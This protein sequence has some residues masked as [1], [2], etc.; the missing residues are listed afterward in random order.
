MI[1]LL[2]HLLDAAYLF[3]VH[4]PPLGA[5]PRGMALAVVGLLAAAVLSGLW[6]RR[7]A[8][9]GR[10]A[11]GARAATLDALLAAVAFAVRPWVAGMVSARVWYVALAAAALLA[12][13]AQWAA[14][15]RW[16]P[17]AHWI[18]LALA[19]APGRPAPRISPA[20]A[21]GWLAL[22]ASGLYAL[23]RGGGGWLPAALAVACLLIA[24][25]GGQRGPLAATA[26]AIWAPLGLVY[27]VLAVRSAL[28]VGLG[29]DLAPYQAFP[30]ADPLSP[31]VHLP[32]ATLAALAWMVLVTG[33]WLRA[34]GAGLRA[35][36]AGLRDEKAHRPTPWP[37]RTL[38]ALAIL[39]CAATVVRHLSHGATGS[40]P[41]CYLQMAADVARRGTP[42]HAFPLAELARRADLPLWPTVHVG[43]HPPG[44]GNLA[45]TVWPPGW[46]WLLAPA[47]GLGGE[48]LALWAAPL[49]AVLAALLTAGV[50]RALWP[51]E[52]SR[53]A[54][55]LAGA[56]ALTS[57]EAVLRS[58]VPMAD[59]AAQLFSVSM[60][61]AL[62]HALRRDRLAW[63]ALAG[64]ALGAAYLV[65]HPQLFLAAGAVGLLMA[66][67]PRRRRW[68]HVGALAAAALLVALP[69]LI[70]HAQVLGSPWRAESPEWHLISLRYMGPTL[71]A[72]WRDGLWR[73]AESGYLWPLI[74]VGAWRSARQAARRPLA[75]DPPSVALM[76]S[77]AGVLAFGLC[78][79][80]LRWRDLI[81]ILPWLALWAAGGAAELWQGPGAR[82]RTAR[83]LTLLLLILMALAARGSQTWSL[84]LQPRA[85]TFGHVSAEQRR[86]FQL[87]AERL[88]DGAVVATG[89]N[90]GAVERYTGCATV[91]PATWSADE[92]DR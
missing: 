19:L 85:W 40:D 81:A 56:L 64:A 35:K 65:R 87:L 12:L 75:A 57:R 77:F 22:H 59:A 51:G 20:L 60:L 73:R 45:A 28:S 86:A 16:G 49:C 18:A 2:R 27:G 8:R 76:A 36:G 68:A 46:P 15:W 53:W 84:P 6:V 31:W 47:Y 3:A 48:A 43:Y 4:D 13:V 50:A 17:R 9:L 42:L 58:L 44:A 62:A 52:E 78:Y 90:S 66:P 88:P 11:W 41:F 89:L 26:L 24:W 72:L 67:W 92:F 25:R 37:G 14:G 23:W 61:L 70:Y 33:A 55:G 32:N 83:R 79:R 82:G 21:A 91:R 38:L 69:D 5:W 34:K 71:V 39:W 54:A 74:L 29:V 80:A 30:Y 10:P 7:L 63:S 1:A